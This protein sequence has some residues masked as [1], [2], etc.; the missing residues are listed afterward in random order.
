MK[1]QTQLITVVSC[2]LAS[3][4]IQS[5][6]TVFANNNNTVSTNETNKKNNTSNFSATASNDSIVL[7]MKELYFMNRIE[8]AKKFPEGRTEQVFSTANCKIKRVI[9]VKGSHGDDY[10]MINYKWGQTFY[11][12]NGNDISEFLFNHDTSGNN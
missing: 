7:I 12:K 11:K 5:N 6:S 1:Y 3:I 10:R 4:F 8:L 2:L 9:V